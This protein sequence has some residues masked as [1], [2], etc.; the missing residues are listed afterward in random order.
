[1]FHRLP[2]LSLSTRFVKSGRGEGGNLPAGRQGIVFDVATAAVNTIL[3]R[4]ECTVDVLMENGT[5]E[6]L[7]GQA[8]VIGFE[9]ELI[10]CH[11]G[12]SDID[13]FVFLE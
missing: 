12:Q 8:L 13:V 6:R 3:F 1:M 7:V 10:E 9:F 5:D 4:L 2:I 11:L